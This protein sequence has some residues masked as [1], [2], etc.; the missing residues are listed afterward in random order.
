MIKI[1]RL[2]NGTEII[3]RLVGKNNKN[4]MLKDPLQIV[5][6]DVGQRMPLVSVARYLQL[7]C[8]REVVFARRDVAHFVDPLPGMKG[9]YTKSVKEYYDIVDAQVDQELKI[10]GETP[11]ETEHRMLCAAAMKERISGEY[12]LH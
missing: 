8:Q 12:S 7:S 11:E 2:A 3:G 9:F 10:A 6:K 5:Y 1:L 4:I